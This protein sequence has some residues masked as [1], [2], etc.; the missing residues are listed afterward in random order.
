MGNILFKDSPQD[1][2]NQILSRLSQVRQSGPSNIIFDK[3]YSSNPQFKQFADGM[4]GKTPEQ[5]FSEHG[6]DFGQFSQ[7]RW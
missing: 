5:A 7:Y 2:G 3:L 1:Q 6:L 4:K